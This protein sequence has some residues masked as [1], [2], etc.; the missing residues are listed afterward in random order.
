[1][2]YVS[3]GRTGVQ[4]S[5]L[6]LGCFNFGLYSPAEEANRIIDRALD[7]GINFIDTA[8]SYGRGV[9]EEIVGEALRR[10]GRRDRVVLATKFW[11]RMDDDDPNAG[12]ASRRHIIEQCEGSLRRLQT[13]H[14]DLY[15]VHRPDTGAALDET[16]RAL[17][18]LVRAGKVRYIGTSNHA[19]WQIVDALWA[20]REHRLNRFISDQPP[21]H[22]LDRRVERELLPMAR[23]YGL[24]V[25]PWS[26]IASGMLGGRYTRGNFA[27]L[28][29]ARF[30]AQSNRAAE[31]NVF[32]AE[33]FDVIEGVEAIATDKGV[34]V[35]QFSLAWVAA[36]P[37]VTAP[38]IG[39]RTLEHLEGYLQAL[40]VEITAEDNARVD[41]LVAPGRAVTNYYDGDY[42]PHRR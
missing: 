20:S 23:T 19:A 31:L 32:S 21:F 2:E 35:S 12:G 15:Q 9:S 7:A 39:P 29:R 6:C 10:N 5:R 4:V 25:L 22:I 27:E 34:P 13:D 1:M 40:A 14:I 26:P 28:D 3:L 37:G 17:D 8:N 30:V 36:Q 24:A 33:A 38:I 42:G 11:G 41:G 18:D 16:L